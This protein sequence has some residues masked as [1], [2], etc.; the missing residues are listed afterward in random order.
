MIEVASG[1]RVGFLLARLACGV[2]VGGGFFVVVPRRVMSAQVIVKQMKYQN[3]NDAV[4]DPL[5]GSDNC[6]L[7]KVTIS[8]TI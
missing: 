4:S 7:V 1:R 2:L 8:V 5:R 3:S 6:Y